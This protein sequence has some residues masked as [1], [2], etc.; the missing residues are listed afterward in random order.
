MSRHNK[1]R[2]KRAADQLPPVSRI[3]RDLRGWK[4]LEYSVGDW[5]PDQ[6]AKLP[7]EAVA[8]SL[9]IDVGDGVGVQMVLRLRTP[10]AVDDMVAS[11][12][13]HR[14][15]VWPGGSRSE[16]DKSIEEMKA[17]CDVLSADNERLREIVQSLADRVA[18]QSEILSKRAEKEV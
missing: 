7:A 13:R 12:E 16:M 11:L 6:D 3:P 14:N 1:D 17:Q 2:R 9:L 18:G 8:L 4:I 15:S 5:C 10:E